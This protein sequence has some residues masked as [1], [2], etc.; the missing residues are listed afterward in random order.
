M[1]ALPL[2][3]NGKKR[4]R[5]ISRMEN[6]LFPP[7]E[8]PWLLSNIDAFVVPEVFFHYCLSK[9]LSMTEKRRERKKVSCHM[10]EVFFKKCAWEWENAFWA[11]TASSQIYLHGHNSVAR[12]LLLRSFAA[13]ALLHP[14]ASQLMHHPTTYFFSASF[15]FAF[16]SSSS[17]AG[18]FILF[19]LLADLFAKEEPKKED[20]RA[21]ALDARRRLLFNPHWHNVRKCHKKVS[22]II[23]SCRHNDLP[24]NIRKFIHNKL[25][26]VNFTSSLKTENPWGT[27]QWSHTD[28]TRLKQ[29]QVGGQVSHLP[30]N[31]LSFTLG[32]IPYAPVMFL[33]ALRKKLPPT[34]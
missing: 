19:L 4:C 15:V 16:T 5:I 30:A 22:S 25:N 21:N 3:A 10:L 24:W 6:S 33:Y 8:F 23:F 34:F 9:N 26:T 7:K 20:Q 2:L 27:S 12:L 13:K 17:E 28:L 14:P 32:G 29:G 18:A 31:A 1:H 11:A